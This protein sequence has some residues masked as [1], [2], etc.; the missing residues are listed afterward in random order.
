MEC[1]SLKREKKK[2]SDAGRKLYIIIF[3]VAANSAC[4]GA[5]IRVYVSF[6]NRASGVVRSAIVRDVP[7]KMP[8]PN[9]NSI[10]DALLLLH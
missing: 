7:H 6:I 8:W 3:R 1:R 2:K 5:G 4:G 10:F 9:K